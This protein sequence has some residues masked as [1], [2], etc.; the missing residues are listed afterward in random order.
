MAVTVSDLFR[1][2]ECDFE[3]L[4][5][6]ID[7]K[8]GVARESPNGA[9]GLAINEI[10]GEVKEADQA[11]RQMEMEAKT[12]PTEQ[13][14]ALEPKLRQH[15]GAL[16]ERHRALDV[17]R[18]ESQ[19]RALDLSTGED[20]GSTLYGKSAQDRDRA[21]DARAQLE[22]STRVLEQARAQAIDSE[23]IGIDVLS[24]LRQQREVIARSRSNMGT[25]GNNYG[26]AKNIIEG[27]HKRA[28]A[29][30]LMMFVVLGFLALVGVVGLYLA[31]GGNLSGGKG[32]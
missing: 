10:H 32:R 30:R 28:K 31:L 21:E 23:Q 22:R 8:L 4:Q 6:S 17:V 18:E 25:I 3:R 7:G 16:N 2:Y 13:R 5:R 9:S 24:D 11:L 14:S 27:M 20:V 19:R 26:M 1:D 12:L 15:R 29:N